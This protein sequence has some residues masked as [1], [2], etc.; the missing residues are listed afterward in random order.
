MNYFDVVNEHKSDGGSYWSMIS[1]I[2]KHLAL[3][4]FT[5]YALKQ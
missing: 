4:P 3:E 1:N 2:L 5:G